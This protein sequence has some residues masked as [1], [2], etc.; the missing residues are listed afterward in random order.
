MSTANLHVVIVP[1]ARHTDGDT[2]R[3]I[4]FQAYGRVEPGPMLLAHSKVKW[5]DEIIKGDEF[6]PRKLAGEFP[7]GQLPVF[8]HKDRYYN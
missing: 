6:I 1:Q 4:Y 2:Y 3:L 7:N 8:V 5:I